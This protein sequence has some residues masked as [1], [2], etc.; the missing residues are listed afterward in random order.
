MKSTPKLGAYL[1]SINEKR[2]LLKCVKTDSK[3]QH[4]LHDFKIHVK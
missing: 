2:N 4:D 3:R 1:I